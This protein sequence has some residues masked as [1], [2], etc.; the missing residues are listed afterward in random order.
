MSDE[1]VEVHC[2]EA[3]FDA[4]GSGSELESA[5]RLVSELRLLLEALL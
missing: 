4:L 5:I 2:P 1:K 3:T